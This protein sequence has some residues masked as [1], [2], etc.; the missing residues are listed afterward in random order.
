MTCSS[1]AVATALDLDAEIG[2]TVI[3]KIR[4]LCRHGLNIVK[5]GQPGQLT[6]MHSASF[7]LRKSTDGRTTAQG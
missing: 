1:D 7:G 6:T 4:A 2:N 3:N 5:V